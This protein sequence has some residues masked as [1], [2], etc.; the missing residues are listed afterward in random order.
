[1]N[2]EEFL[3]S[4]N[5]MR[6]REVVTDAD[7]E[8]ARRVF[9]RDVDRREFL[10]IAALTGGA[11]GL[12]AFL[13]ACA[14][15]A[16]SAPTAAATGP[17]ATAA[18]PTATAGLP[19]GRA[20]KL[21][22]V[23]P[24]TG[25]I[26]GFGESDD[27]IFGGI[28]KAF[29]SGLA[30][31]GKAHPIE[32]VAKD[33]QSDPNR[34][35]SVAGELIDNDKIDLMLVA[36]TP[37]TTNPVADTCE[38]AGMPCLSTVAPWQPWAFRNP[39]VAPPDTQPF[40]WTYHF[41]WGLEDIISVFL[42]MW[43]Q[44]ETN[45]I[46]GGLFPNDGD[47]NA[48]GDA[49]VGFPGPLTA[50]GYTLNDPGRYENLTQSFDAQISAFKT[51]K[52]QILTGVPIP[53]D[54]TNFWKAA[55]S[56]GLKPRIASVGKALLFPAS[57]EA[58]G[59]D[60]GDGLS[61]E[62]WWSP[63]HPFK[64]SLS[65]ETAKALADGYTAATNKQW[66]QPIGFAHALFEI[67]ADTLKRT[68]NID[69]KAAIRDALKGTSL[70]TIVG[71][72]AW[73]AAPEGAPAVLANVAKTPLVGGQWGKGTAFVYDLTIVSNKDHPEIPKAGALRQI[74]GSA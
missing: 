65:G 19:A 49:N 64:S 13:A 57:V 28:Q 7:L 12:T 24:K 43:G 26:A 42:D 52:A 6:G 54:F 18:G 66:T 59:P 9:R 21:G 73:A 46:V 3:V 55:L 39:S 41:F 50:A 22:W 71:H 11:A 10:R 16:S 29:A 20:I 14:P 17:A 30:I 23:S 40:T 5:E 47:G 48:W 25:P 1:V 44:V 37:E 56:Q 72:I 27:Y 33:S 36:S 45:K 70:D 38:A 34:A 8:L 60:D 62:V 35:A 53:P 61:S 74:P 15:A 32:V 58:L 51:A 4:D 63:S 31:N 67:A 69:D 2:L 68:T